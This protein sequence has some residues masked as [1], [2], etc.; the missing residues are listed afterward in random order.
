MARQRI[1]DL[2]V[3]ALYDTIIGRIEYLS[4]SWTDCH[5]MELLFRKSHRSG[6]VLLRFDVSPLYWGVGE[7]EKINS[8]KGK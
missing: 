6:V 7:T 5:K 4:S 8:M 1:C 2:R 3:W